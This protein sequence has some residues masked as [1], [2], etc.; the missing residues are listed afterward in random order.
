MTVGWD[1]KLNF[2]PNEKIGTSACSTVLTGFSRF[3]PKISIFRVFLGSKIEFIR[4]L[5]F[6]D[7]LKCRTKLV[8]TDTSIIA[9][10][11]NPKSAHC[12]HCVRH[13]AT[14]PQVT[15]QVTRDLRVI[16]LLTSL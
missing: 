3:S 10:I 8:P 16:Q 13:F 14:G 6:V 7:S 5:Q 15:P 4:G 9:Y 1:V 12:F 11:S 2:E